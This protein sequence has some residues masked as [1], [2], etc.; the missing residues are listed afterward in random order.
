M[1]LNNVRNIAGFETGVERVFSII[2]QEDERPVRLDLYKHA[3][4][5]VHANSVLR[6]VFYKQRNPDRNS[7]SHSS[8][9][10]GENSQLRYQ[11]REEECD[12]YAIGQV[13]ISI[14]MLM[15]NTSLILYHYWMTLDSLDDNVFNLHENDYLERYQ[16][17]GKEAANNPAREK[18]S[19]SIVQKG[20]H[21]IFPPTNTFAE[22][23]DV[24]DK[25]QR[26]SCLLRS[27]DQ[28][29]QMCHMLYNQNQNSVSLHSI[30]RKSDKSEMD[31]QH[32]EAMTKENKLLRDE[33]YKLKSQSVI[34]IGHDTVSTSL[35]SGEYNFDHVTSIGDLPPRLREMVDEHAQKEVI[36]PFLDDANARIDKANELIKTLKDQVLQ[37]DDE[38][39]RL[40]EQSRALQHRDKEKDECIDQ[41]RSEN[42]KLEGLNQCLKN[43]KASLMQVVEKLY[44][45]AD[46]A[47]QSSPQKSENQVNIHET[48]V[49]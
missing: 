26:Y 34:K 20:H 10:S 47:N 32:M 38:L 5:R 7:S 35:A 44:S 29:L 43:Q 9:Y 36:T 18:A 14:R 39:T 4:L 40:L 16:L 46:L 2:N 19:F 28:L 23:V 33:N 17:S 15:T 13:I 12:A 1:I 48:E 8:T 49:S 11:A 24:E 27:H 42:L 37:K 21:E 25:A 3:T 31:R 30:K 41:L 45:E 22:D 6:I